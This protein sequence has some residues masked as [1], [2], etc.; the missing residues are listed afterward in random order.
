MSAASAQAQIL[1]ALTQQSKVAFAGVVGDIEQ[2]V[3]PTMAAIAHS[4]VVIGERLA[5]GIYTKE[6]AD[7][8]LN[9]Q[10]DAAA[11]VIVRFANKVLK[12]IEDIINAVLAAVQ[13][14][15]NTALKTAFP[16]VPAIL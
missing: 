8:E 4:L 16:G 2:H 15:V 9:A 12:E 6:I 3:I 11:S 5:A 1:N 10:I 13:G 14:V 7:V